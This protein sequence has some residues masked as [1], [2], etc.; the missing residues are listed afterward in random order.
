MRMEIHIVWDD[1][2]VPTKI[3]IVVRGEPHLLQ[4]AAS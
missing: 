2:V 1:S 3:D 4:P